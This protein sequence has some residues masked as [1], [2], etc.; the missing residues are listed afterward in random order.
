MKHVSHN[1]KSESDEGCYCF[2]TD[3][4]ILASLPLP[5][6]FEEK[7]FACLC[8]EM[9]DLEVWHCSSCDHHW[10]VGIDHACKNCYDKQPRKAAKAAGL[11]DAPFE[12][13]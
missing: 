5:R 7:R 10:L 11:S 2:I 12:L 9:F 3:P 8:G 4:E 6:S 13:R 1:K